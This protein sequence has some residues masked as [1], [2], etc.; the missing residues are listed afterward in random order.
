MFRFPRRNSPNSP[1]T[2]FFQTLWKL[3]LRYFAE[4]D[5][6][7]AV[8]ETGIGGLLD[9]TNV[10]T[11]ILSVITKIGFDH[12]DLLG[13]TIEQIASHK[14]GIIKPEVPIITDPTQLEGAMR[15]IRETAA[16][17]N[18]RIVVPSTAGDSPPDWQECNRIVAAAALRELGVAVPDFSPD[19]SKIRLLARMQT[20][21]ENPLTIVDGA[22]NADAIAAVLEVVDSIAKSRNAAADD[23][24]HESAVIVVFGMQKTKDYASCRALLGSRQVVE[25]DDVNCEVQAAAAIAEA[26]RLCPEDGLILV[27]GSLY[28][29]GKVLKSYAA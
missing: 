25:V 28:L 5:V 15:V 10:I 2:G 1:T 6:D 7:Y 9:C 26:R 21:S 20:V 4:Q 13:D 11:P 24:G 18:S 27:C 8:I 17:K 14:A 19:F 23:D 3:A 12:M 29:A 22:H 16:A